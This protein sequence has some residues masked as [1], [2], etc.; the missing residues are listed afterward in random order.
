MPSSLTG[1]VLFAALVLPGYVWIRAAEKWHPRPERSGLTEVAEL[2]F[3]GLVASTTAVT[4][5]IWVGDLNLDQMVREGSDYLLADPQLIVTSALSVMLLSTVGAALAALA[6]Y[7]RPDGI[8]RIRPGS[9]VWFDALTAKNAGKPVVEVNLKDGTRYWGA[10][11]SF[12]VDPDR[13]VPD[14]VLFPLVW[15]AVNNEEPRQLP[16][17]SLIIRGTEVR[18]VRVRHASSP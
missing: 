16:V 8:G 13:E 6:A 5:V 10:V 9:T 1:L 18:D 15:I 2:V 12:S 3:I 14:V 7:R 11:H 4:L 17:D